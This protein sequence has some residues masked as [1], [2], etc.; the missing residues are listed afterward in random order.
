MMPPGPVPSR[1]TPIIVIAGDRYTS[2][3]THATAV[4]SRARVGAGVVRR[5]V[6]SRV[7]S[8]RYARA[9]MRHGTGPYTRR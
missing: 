9:L 1:Q 3:S 5:A 8:A 4:R 2:R 6:S 7:L